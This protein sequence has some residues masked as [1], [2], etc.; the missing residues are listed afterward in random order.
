MTLARAAQA[1]A[2]STTALKHHE[3]NVPLLRCAAMAKLRCG[4]TDG[5]ITLLSSAITIQEGVL[6]NVSDG[7]R[8]GVRDAEEAE[9][10]EEAMV[11]LLLIIAQALVVT[12]EVTASMSRLEAVRGAL[13][14]APASGGRSG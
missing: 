3:A 13:G 1:L 10:E 5:A 7:V 11:D 9:M 6:G 8:R 12:G 2:L 4:D 14:A